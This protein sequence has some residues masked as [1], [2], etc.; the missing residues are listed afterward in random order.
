M[1]DEDPGPPRPSGPARAGGRAMA[2]APTLSTSSADLE[3]VLQEALGALERTRH[4]FFAIAAQLRDEYEAL[5]HELERARAEAAAQIARVDE[6]VR[7]DRAARARLLEIT[8]DPSRHDPEQVRLAY[9]RAREV[10]VQLHVA[11]ERERNLRAL[12]D[13]L[14][15]R[16]RSLGTTLA[17]A[18]DLVGKTSLALELLGGGLQELTQQVAGL[19]L[20]QAMA[21]S[22]LRAQEEERRRLAREIHDGPAQLLANLVFRLEAC[23]R[24]LAQDPARAQA[25]LAHLRALARQGLQEVRAIIFDLRPPALDEQGLLPAL[26]SLVAGFG[27]R[28]GL[29]VEFRAEGPQHRLPPAVAVAAFR[30]VQEALQ[31]VWKHAAASTVEVAVALLDEE[32]RLTVRDDGRGFDPAAVEAGE[33][34]GLIAMR[35]R[36]EMLAGRLEVESAPGRGTTLRATLPLQPRKEG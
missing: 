11:M 30:F 7:Q 29:R 26:R 21:H 1:G 2:E 18:E 24:L 17:R 4:E 8:R 16:L 12:R 28:T 23:E 15:R 20:R 10:Q 35:E 32:V 13:A 9:E 3:Q 33:H 14:E 27:E 6:L 34:Y 19:K 31:N 5:R 36:I 25:E 22:I